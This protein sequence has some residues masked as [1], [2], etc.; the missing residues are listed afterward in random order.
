M[1][2]CDF[3][4]QCVKSQVQ[5]FTL[6]STR[7]RSSTPAVI[8]AHCSHSPYVAEF[9]LPTRG[10]FR[11]EIKEVPD[12]AEIITMREGRIRHPHDLVALAL[13]D[14]NARH[15]AG[16]RAIAHIFCKRRALVRHH[17]KRPATTG[18]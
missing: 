17:G 1:R 15:S 14:R 11:N 5:Y 10:A 18:G 7:S 3:I 16:I 12:T 6:H 13:E 9:R 4:W 8:T 2:S